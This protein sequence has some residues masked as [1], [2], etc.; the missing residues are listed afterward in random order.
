MSKLLRMAQAPAAGWLMFFLAAS[1][2]L[3][4][5]N[6][7]AGLYDEAI[8]LTGGWNVANGAVPH[9]DFYANYGPAQYY[10]LGGLFKLFGPSFLAARV[11]DVIVRA[12][13]VAIAYQ[14]LVNRVRAP[15][16]LAA[17][18]VCA[19]WMG[20]VGFY[21][22][23]TVPA[24]L[25]SLMG[26]MFLLGRDGVPASAKGFATAGA[27]TG[28][29]ALFRYDVGFYAL[30]T[31]AFVLLTI[32]W[33][34]TGPRLERAGSF[35]RRFFLYSTG[36]ALVFMPPAA[37][38]LLAGAGP[39]FL[40]DI[41]AYPS[42]HY[43]AMRSLPFPGWAAILAV[44]PEAASY[45]PFAAV[46]VAAACYPRLGRTPDAPSSS[47]DVDR[48]FVVLLG[49]LCLVFTLKG[50]VRISAIHML[51]A[52][53]PA[54]LL[55]AFIVD[56]FRI[57]PL[58][59]KAAL[60]LTSLVAVAAPTYK[61]LQLAK[62]IAED[63]GMSLAGRLLGASLKPG[64]GVALASRPARTSLETACAAD[65][66]AAVTRPGER[67]FSGTQRHDKIFINNLMLYFA[68]GRRPGT[69]WYQ[70]D[71]GLQT[72]SDT[73]ARIIADLSK[74]DVRWVVTD[75]NWDD[76][77]EPNGSA[78]SSGVRVLDDYLSRNYREVARFGKITLRQLRSSPS[79][80]HRTAQ[81]AMIS[82][83]S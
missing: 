2:L 65:Y 70:F 16:A 28:L 20:G 61:A 15:V 48:I 47:Y 83:L 11:Y 21:L 36:T 43:V 62:G 53:I 34:G 50:L 39:G 78:V 59:G 54:T 80:R 44:P 29:V 38:L 10:V 76:M 13:I 9:R 77:V 69:H 14:L 66:I 17:A 30:A 5:M 27:L 49:T 52:I 1:M 71:P 26:T 64:V 31:H 18:G 63:P 45:L 40:H 74:N 22:Y 42:E 82:Q 51:L 24:L 37:L 35:V 55:L 23:P 75:G 12:A 73:Q 60:A 6:L 19:L 41:I 58:A 25:F 72:R 79:L 57:L 7:Y 8:L 4:F 3:G 56:R 32:S 67:I 46:L 33:A 68:S 81:C